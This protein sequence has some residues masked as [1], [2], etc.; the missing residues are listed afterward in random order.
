MTRA[1]QFFRAVFAKVTEEDR[2][3]I[4][5]YLPQK[6]EKLF[7]ET[8]VFDQAHA[9]SVARSIEE[10]EYAGDKDFLIRLALLHDVGRRN[11]SVFDKVFCVLMNAVSEKF[12]KKL[13]KYVRSLYI[14]YNHPE[15]GAKL[16]KDAGLKKE[17]E[18]I[19]LH[20]TDTE[21]APVE[22]VLLKRADSM[23]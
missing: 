2:E 23:N 9:L 5:K 11:I 13:A 15:I 16:L 1:G 7:F 17:A 4:K 22:L 18:I 21:N 10:F 19:R 12:A 14:Y 6:G 3:Y 8:A 20:H